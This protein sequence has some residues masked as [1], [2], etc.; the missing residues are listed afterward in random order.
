MIGYRSDRVSGTILHVIDY[1]ESE[2]HGMITEAH[3]FDS[4]DSKASFIFFRPEE[5]DEF[6]QR[7]AV[8]L[9]PNKRDLDMILKLTK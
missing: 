9:T 2:Y 4:N 8:D 7:W 6:I 3:C 5:C 1:S